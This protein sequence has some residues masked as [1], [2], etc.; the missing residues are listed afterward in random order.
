MNH[1]LIVDDDPAIRE[2]LE[3]GFRQDHWSV[4]VAAGATEALARFR[5]N[6]SPV[7][8]TDMR[9]DDGD[10]LAVMRGVREIAPDTAVVFL[11]AFGNVP[12]AVSIMRAGG[13]DYLVKPVAFEQIRRTAQQLMSAPT[14]AICVSRAGAI[15]EP[16]TTGDLVASSS[17]TKRTLELARHVARTDADVLIEAESGTGKEMLA[18][19]LHAQGAR[20]KRAFVAVNCAAFPEALLESELFGYV[21]GA[22]TGA[23]ATRVGRF[24]QA[25]G[26]TLL[27]DEIGEMPLNL[28]PKLLRVLQEREIDRLGDVRPIRVDVRI[29]ATTNS[30]LA[31]LVAQGKFRADLYYRLNVVPLTLPPLRERKEDIPALVEHFLRKHAGTGNQQVQLTPAFLQRLQEY[32]WPGNIRE[33]ENTVR[34]ALALSASAEALESWLPPGPALAS[35]EPQNISPVRIAGGATWQQ[36]ERDL[37]EATLRA[38]NGNR[39]R[40][41]EMLGL[42][43]RTIRNK[44]RQ[45]QL[46]PARRPVTLQAFENATAVAA[47]GAR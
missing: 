34:R 41:A 15:E 24:E 47:G 36:A 16:E 13:C 37:L 33:L 25:D 1:V 10:G 29:I 19:F 27:L 14:A 17:I 2:A 22:F 3:T 23:T 5:A 8:I 45:Y 30:S 26:G 31:A 46:P 32:H 4:M 38:T 12:D 21:R 7:V 35:R 18:R 44:I 28:Q 43:V 42:S 6:P 20:R 11:T 40:A 9:L 39:T